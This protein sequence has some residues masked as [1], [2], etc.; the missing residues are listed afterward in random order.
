MSGLFILCLSWRPGT[1]TPAFLYKKR[2]LLMNQK[3]HSNSPF[4]LSIFFQDNGLRQDKGSLI[5]RYRLVDRDV[6][7]PG[8]R[9][10]LQ[11]GTF[12]G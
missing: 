7:I 11:L 1:E 9:G 4:G 10:V 12:D 5:N 8:D 6:L 3:V 2:L